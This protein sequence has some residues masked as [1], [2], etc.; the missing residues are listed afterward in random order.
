MLPR[1][2]V[3]LHLGN[4]DLGLVLAFII[5]LAPLLVLVL[6]DDVKDG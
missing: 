2:Y 4:K 5:R 3:C 1:L 6:I